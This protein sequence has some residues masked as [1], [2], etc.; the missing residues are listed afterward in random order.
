[1]AKVQD[2]FQTATAARVGWNPLSTAIG[3]T[4]NLRGFDQLREGQRKGWLQQHDKPFRINNLP[5]GAGKSYLI[6]AIATHRMFENRKL[7]TWICVPETSIADGF[8]DI[9]FTLPTG[10]DWHWEIGH[11]LCGEKQNEASNTRYV[12]DWLQHPSTKYMKGRILISTHA[13]A[14]RVYQ[15]LAETGRLDLLK[16]LNLEIDEGHHL[17]NAQVEGIGHEEIDAEMGRN[18]IGSLVNHFW[19]NR[20]RGLEVGITT[21]TFARG[22]GYSNLTPEQLAGFSRFNLPYDEYLPTLQHLRSFQYDFVCYDASPIKAIEHI[23]KSN[24]KGKFLINFPAVGSN[25]MWASDK[26]EGVKQVLGVIK[27]TYGNGKF[28]KYDTHISLDAGNGRRIR[29]VDLVTEKGRDRRKEYLA[30]GRK[31]SNAIDI[32]I[33]LGMFKE[34]GDWPFCDNIICI[35]HRNSVVEIGQLLGRGLRDVYK[36]SHVGFWHLLPFTL[37]ACD[38]EEFGEQ[39]NGVLKSLYL[40]MLYVDCMARLKL[41][42]PGEERAGRGGGEVQDRVSVIDEQLPDFNDQIRLQDAVVRRLLEINDICGAE[43]SA[44]VLWPKYQEMMPALLA[45]F[46]VTESVEDISKVIWGRLARL[47]RQQANLNFID[48]E[49]EAL[50]AVSPLNGLLRFSSGISGAKTLGDLRLAMK[51]TV[52][53]RRTPAEWVPIAERMANA[54]GGQLQASSWLQRNGFSGLDSIIRKFPHL[55]AHVS[56]HKYTIHPE[57]WIP[58]AERL[59]KENGGILPNS[60]WLTRNGHIAL[61]G[62]MRRRPELFNHIEQ[63]NDR[64]LPHQW[65]PVAERLAKK[66]GGTLPNPAWLRD[67][68]HN[69]LYQAIRNHSSLF[70]HIEKGLIG[71]SLFDWVAVADRLVKENDGLLPSHA[72]LNKNGHI[73]LIGAMN[74]KPDMFSHIKQ[75]KLRL[76]AKELVPVAERLAKENGGLLPCGMWLKNNGHTKLKSAMQGNPELFSK[77]KQEKKAGCCVGKSPS[78]WV[79]VAERLAKSKGGELPYSHWLTLNGYNGLRQAMLKEPKLFKHIPQ[80]KRCGKSPDYWVSVAERLAEENGGTLPNM[81]ALRKTDNAGL[82]SAMR[83]HPNLFSHIKQNNLRTAAEDWIPVAE[84]LAKKNNGRLPSAKWLS[85]N[86]YNGLRGALDRHPHLFS[87]IQKIRHAA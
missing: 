86:G 83:H 10:M 28:T 40:S 18:R 32:I 24:P 25:A 47:T 33:S 23:I 45:K 72:W 84:R 11:P 42:V 21:A 54:N 31:R 78:Q 77:L 19:E 64:M 62:A 39:L 46:G 68:G 58:V 48:V 57:K 85:A 35:G 30:E 16:D 61:Y 27:K 38:E 22:D 41:K 51:Y 56:Q 3:D 7:R 4:T 34:G 36:K 14:V 5:T 44:D 76:R 29:I 60:S 71:V 37:K 81:A 2:K 65:V 13:T 43:G 6:A 17:L 63:A 70:A 52:E 55:F 12:I 15:M 50:K 74:R 26:Y 1:M 80:E 9:K 67:N 66:N 87:H 49:F 53:C 82:Y 73:G 79:P 69:G 20:K 8:L 59:A 75:A